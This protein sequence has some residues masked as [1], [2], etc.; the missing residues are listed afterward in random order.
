MY[1]YLCIYIRTYHFN[2]K[3]TQYSN[4]VNISL[5]YP[6]SDSV[7]IIVQ[8][9]KALQRIYKSS[10]SYHKLGIILSDLSSDKI[11]QI[12]L[13]DKPNYKKSDKLMATLDYINSNLGKNSVFIGAPRGLRILGSLNAKKNL[14]VILP[15]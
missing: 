6:S 8:S 1:F 7:E 15:I 2:L 12:Q 3:Q 10:Y 9:K 13:F 14:L 5:P 11:E 4:S